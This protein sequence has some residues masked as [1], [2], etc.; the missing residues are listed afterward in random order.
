MC[1]VIFCGCISVF[2]YQCDNLFILRIMICSHYILRHFFLFIPAHIL[3]F[4][5]G[6][7][8]RSHGSGIDHII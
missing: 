3:V 5:G 2:A 7:C 8:D 6:I 4:P 1:A